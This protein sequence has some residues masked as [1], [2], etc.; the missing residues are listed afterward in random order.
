MQQPALL[1]AKI[2]QGN[3][4]R[5]GKHINKNS[6]E[7]S[8]QSPDNPLKKLVYAFSCLLVKTRNI[9]NFAGLS[10]ERVGGVAFS[11]GTRETHNRNSKK[12]SGKGRDSPGQSWDK[13]GTIP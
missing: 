12:I 5:K 11:G 3:L 10:R 1:F 6:Q 9:N 2:Y 7:I 4:G 13:T 8:G